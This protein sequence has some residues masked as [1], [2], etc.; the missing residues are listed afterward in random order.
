MPKGEKVVL[1][2]ENPNPCGLARGKEVEVA[3]AP[4]KAP[5]GSGGEKNLGGGGDV[6]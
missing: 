5:D 6:V 1:P 3:R 2:D 4:P